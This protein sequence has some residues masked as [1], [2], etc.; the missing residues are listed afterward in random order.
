MTR[1]FKLSVPALL[2]VIALGFSLP[3]SAQTVVLTINIQQMLA[4][5]PLGQDLTRQ[6]AEY[7]TQ[8]AAELQQAGNAL[9]AEVADLQRQHDEFIITDEV[10]EQQIIELQQRDRQLSARANLG[11]QLVQYARGAV[12]EFFVQA[13][14]ADIETV[15]EERGG[16]V[17]LERSQ[18]FVSADET[19]ITPEVMERVNGRITE[20][21]IDLRPPQPQPPTEE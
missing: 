1:L 15:L 9:Q 2:A 4:E 3:A 14:F 16:Q 18:V 6:L 11:N 13:I 7:E 10:F 19:D 8:I 20:L 21:E 17:L 12:P 5:T